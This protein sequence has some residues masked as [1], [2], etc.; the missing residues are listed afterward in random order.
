MQYPTKRQDGVMR[1]NMLIRH[2]VG[3]DALTLGVLDILNDRLGATYDLGDTYRIEAELKHIRGSEVEEAVRDGL[4]R[5]G[6]QWVE[7]GHEAMSVPVVEDGQKL[8]EQ[9][10][11]RRWPSYWG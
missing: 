2:A 5:G 6:Y 3:A 4:Q 8:A 11:K 9:F 10:V 1:S 7:F